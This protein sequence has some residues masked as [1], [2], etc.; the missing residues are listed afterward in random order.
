MRF[1]S[2]I[3]LALILIVGCSSGPARRPELLAPETTASKA[4]SVGVRAAALAARYVGVPYRLGGGSPEGFDCSGLVWFVYHQL[5]VTVPRTAA[6]QHQ[7]ARPIPG[8]QLK[9]GDLV[10]FYTSVDHVGIYVGNGEF[11]HAPAT[12]KTVTRARLNSPYF[13]LGFAGGGRLPGV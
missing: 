13:I 4:D 11:V 9:P 8:D 2:S 10:F 6:L 1:L 3:L 5:G 7:A 12:G